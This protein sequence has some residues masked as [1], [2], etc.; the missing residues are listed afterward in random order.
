MAYAVADIPSLGDTET[1]EGI[2]LGLPGIRLFWTLPY[3]VESSFALL[4]TGNAVYLCNL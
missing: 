1:S 3:V 2:A 4:M